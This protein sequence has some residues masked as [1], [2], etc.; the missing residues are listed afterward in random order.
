MGQMRVYAGIGFNQSF[1][2]VDSLNYVIQRYN[3]LNE[4]EKP[5]GEISSPRGLAVNVGL[6]GKRMLFDLGYTMRMQG[7]RSREVENA[8]GNYNVRQVSFRMHTFD[9]GLGLKLN[10]AED[11]VYALGVAL[12]IG[13]IRVFTRYGRNDNVNA[14]PLQNPIVSEL[15]LG[16]TAFF[17]IAFPLSP[18]LPFQLYLR[19]YYYFSLYRND[20]GPLNRVVNIPEFQDDPLFLLSPS[21]NFGLKV[22]ILFGS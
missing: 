3:M 8:N 16:T 4:T 11:R 13:T 1:M 19:P 9:M 15:C 18:D 14:L 10:K 2:Q 12:N 22:G 7:T 20:Y 21:N 17:H 6:I 5:L